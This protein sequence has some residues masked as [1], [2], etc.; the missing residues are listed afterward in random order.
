[1]IS[2]THPQLIIAGTRDLGPQLTQNPHRMVGQDG[3][4][5]IPC[6]P[7]TLWYFGDTLVGKRTP[8]ESLWYPG[9]KPVGPDDMSGKSGIERMLNNTGLLLPAQDGRAG[10]V[11]YRYIC[12]HR[13]NLRPLIPLDAGEHPDRFRIWCLHGICMED[14]VI[15]YFI[16][17]EMIPTGPFPVNFRVVGSGMAAGDSTTWI[18]HRVYHN[19]SCIV[20]GENDPHFATAVLRTNADRWIYLY[21]SKQ[22]DAG[23]QGAYLARVSPEE[24]NLPDSYEYLSSPTPSWG[25]LVADSVPVFQDMPNELSVSYNAHLGAYLAVHSLGL[26]GDIVARTAPFPWGPWSAPV[27]LWSVRPERNRPLPYPPLV[28]A[29]KEHPSLSREGG[30]ILYITYVEFEEYYPHLVELTLA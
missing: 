18:F 3:A 20:W 25:P 16:K 21:G 12:D 27:K 23:T 26:S 1:M 7:R 17:V 8:G 9:G 2:G 15:L 4:F 5:S 30:R 29:G 24:I 19:G 28:Y 10:L 11:S 13:G 14:K 22:D 6:G